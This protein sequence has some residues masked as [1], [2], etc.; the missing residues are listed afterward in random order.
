[1]G[2]KDGCF[3]VRSGSKKIVKVTEGM[4][5]N[6]GILI[7]KDSCEEKKPE[8]KREYINLSFKQFFEDRRSAYQDKELKGFKIE[9]E[10]VEELA[11]AIAEE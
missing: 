10:V 4:M 7:P 9:D 8:P 5:M 1:M 6:H 2:F 3:L 11:V